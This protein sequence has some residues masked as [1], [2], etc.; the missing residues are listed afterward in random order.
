[1]VLVQN[2]ISHRMCHQN[3]KKKIAT[4]EGLKFWA[5]FITHVLH[6]F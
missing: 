4:H 3:N 5:M 2:K 1:M 6:Y